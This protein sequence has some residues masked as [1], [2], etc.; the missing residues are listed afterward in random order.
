MSAHFLLGGARSG[1]SALA[2]RL[3]EESG[4]PVTVIVTGEPRDAEMAERIARHRRERPAHWRTVEAPCE[5]AGAL[6]AHAAPERF[7]LVDC[8][9]LW[10]SNWLLACLDDPPRRGLDEFAA[11][12]AALLELVAA[13]PGPLV[14]VA[15]EVGL[16]LVPET[17]L[18]RRFRDEAGRLNQDVA[19][20]ASAV[21][22]VAAGL[23]L[24]LK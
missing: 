14:L 13:P 23:P 24:R 19:A 9:T 15:N 3:A 8:L 22:F 12:R 18:G 21:S 6:R 17:A 11:E 16:G 7:V 5:L 10:L 20:R 4:L 2:Q 1:K